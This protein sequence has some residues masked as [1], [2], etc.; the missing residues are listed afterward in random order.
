MAAL[1]AALAVPS[2]AQETWTSTS[3]VGAPSARTGD[4][5][6]WTGSKMIVWGGSFWD[7]VLHFPVT[8]D[9]GGIHDPVTNTWTATSTAGAPEARASHT[10]VW[11]GSTMIVWG[12][13][14]HFGPGYLNSGGIYDPATDTWSAIPTTH[15]PAARNGHTAVWTG[16]TM[17][18]W[19]GFGDSGALNTGGIYDPSTDTWTTTSTT[20]APTGRVGHTAVWTGSGMIVWGGFEGTSPASLDTGGIYHPE[21]DT[22][23]ATSRTGSPAP[24][25][26]HTAVWTGSTMIVWGGYESWSD[27]RLNSG[28]VPLNSGGLYDP[29]TDTWTATARTDAPVARDQHTAV[30]TGSRMIV[31]GGYGTSHLD[32]G[33]I[34]DLTTDAWTATSTTG[35]PEPRASHAA[36]WTGSSMI[37]WGGRSD[38]AL[39]SG[40]VYTNPTLLPLPP[41]PAG[42]YTVT[43]CRLVDTRIAAG[44]S[45]GPALFPGATRSF[46]VTG[47][48]CGIPSTATAVSVNVTAVQPTAPGFLTLYRGDATTP[49]PT[50]NVSFTSAVTRAASAVV[51]VAANGGTINVKNGSAGLVHLVLDVNG[52]FQ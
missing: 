1:L 35:A 34:Y 15:A 44:S 45:G 27:L 30:W 3:T 6:V 21:I 28:G 9:S 20:N 11:T 8:L 12:G 37:V 47:G 39:D 43:P 24:R 41:P 42:F 25:Q 17:I 2:A 10:A 7:G 16:S 48:V 29:A 46:P 5:A 51:T 50:S 4:S 26:S 38:R 13:S 32:T 36:A 14:S 18:V 31:W 52:Y 22:W 49:P 19:G 40:A 23:T 33:G